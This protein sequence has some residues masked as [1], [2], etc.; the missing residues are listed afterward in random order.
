MH[1]NDD[2]SVFPQDANSFN[3]VLE[4]LSKLEREL[5]PKDIEQ[6]KSAQESSKTFLFR[7]ALTIVDTSKAFFRKSEHADDFL[8]STWVALVKNKAI[9]TT[10]EEPLKRFIQIDES[11][12]RELAKL[13]SNEKHL[14]QLPR[15]LAKEFGVILVIEPPLPSMKTDGCVMTLST[16]TPVIGLSLRY[17]R[18]DYFWFTLM[19]EMSH[20]TLHYNELA[21]PIIDNLDEENLTSS[22][23]EIEANRLTADSF[24]PRNIWRKMLLERN[25]KEQLLIYSQ[26]AEIHPAIAAGLIR[27]NQKN[28]QIYSDLVNSIDVSKEFGLAR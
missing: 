19:H 16:G 3:D 25:S 24:V 11:Q 15:I 12:L 4:T 17:N 8:A 23:K 22:D 18:Y 28:Y 7:T 2:F 5:R 13:S 21:T 9:L 20:I 1:E 26:Q 14:K 27:F 10:A 6:R